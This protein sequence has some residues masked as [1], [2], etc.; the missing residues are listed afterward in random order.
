MIIER[1][2]LETTLKPAQRRHSHDRYRPN[3]IAQTLITD[4]NKAYQVLQTGNS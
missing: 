2:S 3:Q 1:Q 4:L